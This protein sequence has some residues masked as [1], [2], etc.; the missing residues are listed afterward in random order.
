MAT[1]DIREIDMTKATN[2]DGKRQLW[3]DFSAKKNA[4]EY[5]IKPYLKVYCMMASTLTTIKSRKTCL[6]A[7]ISRIHRMEVD[8]GTSK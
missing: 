8:G 7:I 5:T 1:G 3:E 6:F 4:L 2:L